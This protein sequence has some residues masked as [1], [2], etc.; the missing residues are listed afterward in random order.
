MSS[1]SILCNHNNVNTE[2]LKLTTL[3]RER[4][5]KTKFLFSE[6]ESHHVTK[7]EKNQEL[8]L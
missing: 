7:T 5:T 1:E 6:A 3:R 2:S 8:A 4:G